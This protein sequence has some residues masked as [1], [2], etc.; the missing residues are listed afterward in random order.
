MPIKADLYSHLTE[1]FNRIMLHNPENGYEN[2]EEISAL[3]KQTNF[4]IQDPALDTDVNAKAGVVSNK[5]MFEQI[6][7]WKNLLNEYP[8]LV[9]KEDRRSYVSKEVKCVVP[10]FVQHAEMF[11]WA[12][13]GFGPDASYVIQKSI[14]RLAV[15]SGATSIKFFG[16]ILCRNKDYWVAQGTLPTQEQQPLNKGQ[17]LRG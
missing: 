6:E 13:I 15:M 14:K 16:K 17:E 7:K 1:V 9:S 10:N 2:F 8:D 5:E 11:E 4:K 3:V 12:G